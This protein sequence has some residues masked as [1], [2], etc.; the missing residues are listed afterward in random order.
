MVINLQFLELLADAKF[1]REDFGCHI[2]QVVQIMVPINSLYRKTYGLS[3]GR[4]HLKHKNL[5][6]YLSC[7]NFFPLSSVQ[8]FLTPAR[9]LLCVL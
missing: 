9:C 6:T 4:L 7:H 5:N 8:I 3:K 1:P 2:N